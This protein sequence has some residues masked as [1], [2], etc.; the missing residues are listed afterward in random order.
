MNEVEGLPNWSFFVAIMNVWPYGEKANVEQI[1][2]SEKI[3]KSKRS[4]LW[5]LL[6]VIRVEKL[7]IRISSFEIKV[8]L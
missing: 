8:I 2:A 3:N 4:G 5:E 6:S 1:M 7:T